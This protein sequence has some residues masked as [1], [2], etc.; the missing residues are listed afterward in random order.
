MSETSERAPVQRLK[1]G[2]PWSM[3]MRA[4]AVYAKRHGEQKALIEGGCRGGFAVGEL[5]MFIPGWREEFELIENARLVR[6]PS[7][8]KHQE[9]LMPEKPN[10]ATNTA[11]TQAE[12]TS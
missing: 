7:F 5:D 12:S 11:K 8:P 1:G 6:D 9:Y 3:H 4:Y 2:I 10:P